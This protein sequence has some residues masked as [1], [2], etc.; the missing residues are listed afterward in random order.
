MANF[1]VIE[2]LLFQS[3]LIFLNAVFACAEIAVISVNENKL[4]KLSEEGNKKAKRLLSLMEQPAKFLATIQVGITLAGFLGSAFAADNFSDR[5]VDWL[6]AAGVTL[7]PAKLDVMAVIGITLILSY[8]TLILGEL[9]PKRIAMQNAEKI[10]LAM[11][12]PIYG[13]AK[14]FAPLVWFLTISTNIVLK[15]LGIS[16]ENHDERVTEEEIRI[17]IDAGSKS[18]AIDDTEKDLLHNV[19]EF[20]DTLAEEVM[21]HRTEVTFLN[22]DD[23]PQKWEREMIDTRYS[24]YP[25][26]RGS[27]D[28]V[29]GSLSIKD[30]F[31]FKDLDKED[32]LRQALKPV[33]FIPESVHVNDLF[34]SMQ[35]SRNHFVVVVDEYGGV[36]GIVTMSDLLEELVGDLEDDMTAPP[37]CPDI[38]QVGQKVWRIKGAAA[39]D[40]V[41]KCIGVSLPNNECETFGGFVLSLMGS[42]PEDKNNIKL[43][44][45]NLKIKVISAK[46]HRIEDTLVQMNDRPMS[47]NI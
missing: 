10:G 43:E 41:M 33:Q 31:K 22:A 25:V 45:G 46:G 42:I 17:M 20:N 9:V 7:S 35:K 16:P 39:I 6:I 34:Q 2:L 40:E 23:T 1:T 29:I 47:T 8:V 28:N 14:I 4:N 12:G 37:S 18:G 19:F 44:Y 3:L 27:N 36:D 26:F 21:T 11:S 5:I 13:V 15:L 32:I 38:E 30:Y 24:V